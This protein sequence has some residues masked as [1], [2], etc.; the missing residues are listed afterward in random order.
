[1]FGDG[2]G[3]LLAGQLTP[4]YVETLLTSCPQSPQDRLEHLRQAGKY[5]GEHKDRVFESKVSL[6]I[7][8]NVEY[9]D[10]SVDGRRRSPASVT[11][12]HLRA[13]A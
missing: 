5:F 10:V 13:G 6:R 12:N 1:M 3:E 11:A 9:A 7:F 8:E 4:H 2:R